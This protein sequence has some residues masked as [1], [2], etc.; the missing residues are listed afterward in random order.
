M[1]EIHVGKIEWNISC[2]AQHDVIVIAK[3]N[4]IYIIPSK[5]LDI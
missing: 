1:V 5:I 3:S 2:V 4:V